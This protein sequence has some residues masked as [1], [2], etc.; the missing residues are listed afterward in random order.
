MKKFFKKILILGGTL[1]AAHFGFKAYKKISG[2]AKLS[3]SLP[4]FLNNVYGEMPQVNVNHT[5][6][7]TRIKV[8]FSQ[9][10]LDKHTDIETT[11][12]E[13]IDDF[14][15]EIAKTSVDISIMP[16]TEETEDIPVEEETEEKE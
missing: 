9:E 6:N 14:Y 13:Y 4:E 7:S 15:P 10:I 5:L 11:I 2:T 3:K 1:A 16:A 12:R 8:F